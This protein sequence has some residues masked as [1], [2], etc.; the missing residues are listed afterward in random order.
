MKKA[1]LAIN[2]VS[3]GG[4]DLN[5]RL[6]AY[7]EAGFQNV[8]FQ[9]GQVWAEIERGRSAEDIRRALEGYGLRCIGGFETDLAVF[10]ETEANHARI[11]KNAELL[12]VLGGTT[13]VVGV[14]GWPGE[15]PADPVGDAA[16][17]AGELAERMATFGVRLAIE[18]NWS[19][20]V[21]SLRTAVDIAR[22]SESPQ[23][24]VLFDPA[25]YHCTPSKF[26]Q[27]DEE[28]VRHLFHV[29]VDDMRDKPGELSDCNSDRELPGE[30]ILPL[31]EIFGRIEALG[32][33]GYFS[34]E[35]FSERLWSLPAAEAAKR[36]Y[37]SLL[38]LCD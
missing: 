21:K 29:H 35:M 33:D 2:S 5:E 30:G 34:I 13:L 31:Q 16:S 3:T 18:F 8:E 1:Q 12:G 38:S 6:S 37:A 14:G 36:M 15:R 24:G 7:T 20:W 9:L 26:D 25:H 10:G 17:V 4:A 23:V 19:P 11:L 22:R 27:L 32:Y 28:A